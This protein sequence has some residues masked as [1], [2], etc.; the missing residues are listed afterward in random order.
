[1]VGDVQFK[2]SSLNNLYKIVPGVRCFG[3]PGIEGTCIFLG[4]RNQY[5]TYSFYVENEHRIEI[6]DKIPPID[7]FGASEMPDNP[8][9]VMKQEEPYLFK[10]FYIETISN[11]YF[12]QCLEYEYIEIAFMYANDTELYSEELEYIETVINTLKQLL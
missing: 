7:Y 10:E 3:V 4:E 5:D 1:M 6:I 11:E 12:I 9:E 8:L 2:K